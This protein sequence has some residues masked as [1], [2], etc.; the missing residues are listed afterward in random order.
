MIPKHLHGKRNLVDTYLTFPSYI[1]T[2]TELI[3]KKFTHG[4][5]IVF[6][7]RGPIFMIQAMIRTG[8]LAP[9]LNYLWYIRQ[10]LKCMVQVRT[11]RKLQTSI[12]RMVLQKHL[13]QTRALQLHI[14]LCNN[15]HR[16]IMTTLQR[17]IS[18]I[19]LLKTFHKTNLVVQEVANT[20]YALILTLN[21]RK[22]TDIDVCK[23]LFQFLS[24]A[25]LFS[26]L[27]FFIFS[28]RTS[29]YFSTLGVFTYP[30]KTSTK[31]IRIATFK[32][33]GIIQIK[34]NHCCHRDKNNQV[35]RLNFCSSIF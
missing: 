9:L 15:H 27:T 19:L 5:Q 34:S 33:N 6:W 35:L 23:S 32:N 31:T 26:I 29:F 24:S 13:S 22:Y 2:P 11:M 20:T 14:D 17:L 16:G 28:A 12:T 18:T 10:I 7:S 3:L 30:S 21:T 4:D 1:L 8:K 25:I